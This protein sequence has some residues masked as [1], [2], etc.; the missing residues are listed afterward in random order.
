[1]LWN[2]ERVHMFGPNTA[3]LKKAMPLLARHEGEWR[4][5]YL[6]FDASGRA[7]DEHKSELTCLFPKTG[8]FPYVQI[9]RYFW[10]DGKEQLLRLPA[11]FKKGQ[12]IW[13]EE[14]I[15]GRAWEAD[16]KTLM[17]KWLHRGDVTNH[18]YEIIHLH[19]D[20][21]ERT[22]TLTWFRDDRLYR[23]TLISETRIN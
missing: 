20:D 3:R 16:D 18:L 11:R 23:R 19:K 9:S 4:G 12:L 13:Q 5:T 15:Q 7:Q 2:C 14:F 22:R 21:T 8:K 10:A 6:H 1:M 17:M